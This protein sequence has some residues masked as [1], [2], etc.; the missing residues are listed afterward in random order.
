MAATL[1]LLRAFL[2]G[3]LLIQPATGTMTLPAAVALSAVVL[4]LVPVTG[5]TAIA[6]HPR[7]VWTGSVRLTAVALLA[8]IPGPSGQLLTVIAGIGSAAGLLSLVALA[9]TTQAPRSVRLGLLGG[10]A[11]EALVRTATSGLGLL[12]AG[13]VAA[14]LSTML[15]AI[16]LLVVARS[17]AFEP[18]TDAGTPSLAPPLLAW[19]WLL[20]AVVLTGALTGVP[21]RIAVATGW[22]SAQAAGATATSLVLAMVAALLAPRLP[23]TRLG[24]ATAAA[25]LVGTAASLPAA[26]WPAA[27]GAPAVALGLG[28]LAG[29]ES[30]RD[31]RPTLQRR[32]LAPALALAGAMATLLVYE[33]APS[34][35]LPANVRPLLLLAVGLGGAGLALVAGRRR[36]T[37]TVRGRLQTVPTLTAL[38]AGAATIAT[39]TLLAPTPLH[40]LP[41]GDSATDR[42]EVAT[43][44]VSAGFGADGRYDPLRQTRLLRDHAVDLVLLTGIDRGSWLAGGQDVLPLLHANTGLEHVLFA[45]AASEVTGHAL[46]SRYPITEFVTE[47]LPGGRRSAVHSQLV[48]VVTLPDGQ[49]LGVIGT[50]LAVADAESEAR[51]PQVRAI[52]GNV[53]RLRERN[54][55]TVLLGDLG[56]PLEGAVRDSFDPLLP[57]TMPDGARNFP[58][59]GPVELRDHVLLSERL[60]RAAIAIPAE[61]AATHLPVVVTVEGVT[62]QP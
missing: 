24:P 38:L 59:T 32:A 15:L 31:R 45:P 9:T 5:T 49:E 26:G 18:D 58:A 52:A 11:A 53:A 39:V 46:M 29:L 17:P 56:G 44:S 8:L 43:F 19:G 10:L 40:P 25:L 14:G 51:L 41:A 37:T 61:P 35:G 2:P 1:L 60:R 62:T 36:P 48:A 7:R 33:L 22:S 28:G 6:R 54:L 20:P 47:P 50:G 16:A 42:L 34:V 55:P 3:L 23:A 13:T 4:C 57:G 12:W 21:G 30:T 27:L